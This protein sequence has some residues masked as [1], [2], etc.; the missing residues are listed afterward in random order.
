MNTPAWCSEKKP[1]T[2]CIWRRGFIIRDSLDN[3]IAIKLATA[4]TTRRPSKPATTS[5]VVYV[6]GHLRTNSDVE[7]DVINQ[8]QKQLTLTNL[9]LF[10]EW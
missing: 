1:Q 3:S 4:I 9:Y 2:K 8:N 7:N 5:A 6:Y 10:I